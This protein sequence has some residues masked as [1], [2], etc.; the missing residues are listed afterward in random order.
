MVS[1]I[2]NH[3]SF[4][5]NSIFDALYC[6]EEH[7]DENV[8]C[9]SGL[10]ESETETEVIREIRD[11]KL[12]Q[13]LLWE[14]EE[15]V[16][17]LDKEKQQ[18]GSIYEE[19]DSD[20]DLKAV[21]SAA[22][23]WMMKV[24]GYY[25]FNATTAVLAAN[26]FDRFVSSAC[27][28]KD[29][30]WMGQLAAVACLSIA[31]KVEET[32]VPLLLDLQVEESKYFFESKT[33]LRME[34][35]ILS[36]LKWKMNPAT[37]IS[38]IDHIARRFQSMSNLPLEFLRRCESIAVSIIA[39]YR[40][41]RYLPSVIAAAIIIYVVKESC[42]A[43]EYQNQLTTVLKAS[44]ENIDECGSLIAEAMGG[45]L[46]CKPCPKRKHECAPPSSPSGVIDTYFSSDSSVDS[47]AAGSQFSDPLFKRSRT[48]DQQHP[49]FVD[50]P[51]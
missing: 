30:P 2:Q 11:E 8:G 37:P 20:A 1:H 7:F 32:N 33:I 14:D 29:K 47:W 42:D 48:Q 10:K 36:T 35:L 21:R 45:G 40:L 25:G 4:L 39:D 51:R 34:L 50:Y 26:Y 28:R 49:V 13:D 12:G 27:Y 19:I 46:T 5:H 9:G 18:S 23:W 24:I 38:F 31:A 15:V 41:C 16:A 43:S 22:I 17:L 44:V 6:D 3:E